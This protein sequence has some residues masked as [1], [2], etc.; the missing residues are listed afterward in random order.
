MKSHSRKYVLFML[1]GSLILL[2]AACIDLCCGDIGI[3]ELVEMNMAGEILAGVRLPRVLTAALAGASLAVAGVQMQAIFRNPLADPHIMGISSGAGTAAA[4]ATISIGLLPA[5]AGSMAVALAA[6][7]GAMVPSAVLIAVSSKVRGGG[8]LLLFGVMMGFI[9]SALTLIIAYT[10][11]EESLKVYYSWA[12]GSFTSSILL[13]DLIIATVLIGAVFIALANA[14]GLDIILFG[15][16]Y[17]AASGAPVKKIRTLAIVSTCIL[18]GACTAFCGPIGFIGIIAPH[19]T[20]RIG[21][22]SVHRQVIPESMITGAV[23]ALIADMLTHISKTP[24]PA[25]ST[26]ALIAIPTVFFILLNG[27]KQ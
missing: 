6:F 18:T 15:E 22:S 1:S 21:G 20:R 11:N 4:I 17:C 26:V 8:T 5:V 25:G 10:A 13:Y 27:S 23:I 24:L 9:F 19:I 14:K 7:I 3:A 12:A 16:E 2:L